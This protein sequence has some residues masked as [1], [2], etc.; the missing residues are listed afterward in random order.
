MC[1]VS[2]FTADEIKKSKEL[3][4]DSIPAS[5]RRMSRKKK[6]KEERDLADIVNL[7]KS[8]EP[9]VMLVFVA[10]Q[11]EKLPP[12]LFN[13]LDCT[14]LLKDLLL[15]RADIEKVKSTYVKHDQLSDLKLE[16]LHYRNDSLPPSPVPC[17]NMQR[18]ACLL[19]SGSLDVSQFGPT[20]SVYESPLIA[21]E[22]VNTKLRKLRNIIGKCSVVGNYQQA[23]AFDVQSGQVQQVCPS[24]HSTSIV[25][26]LCNPAV[27]SVL[28]ATSKQR[29]SSVRRLG[30]V[31][32]EATVASA[33][34]GL[35]VTKPLEIRSQVKSA[36]AVDD[37][38]FQFVCRRNK[39]MKY[40][41][42]GKSGMARDMECIFKAADKKVPIFMTNVHIDTVQ[43]DIVE[44]INW[45]RNLDEQFCPHGIIFRRFVNFKDQPSSNRFTSVNGQP[46]PE[47]G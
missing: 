15:L 28:P 20:R 35:V 10:R 25:R 41:Y 43:K 18:G 38:G 7:F 22:L 36:V 37:D 33:Q 3:L 45:L 11:L 39:R 24:V 4:F 16:F 9:D 2:S 5:L 17:V 30:H 1:C 34:G 42:H 47:Y 6:G 23:P 26:G 31:D 13:H 12:I 27:E 8:A 19:S 32:I 46:T 44:Y 40:R 21:Q 14:K 29:S